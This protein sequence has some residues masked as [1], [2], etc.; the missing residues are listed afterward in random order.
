MIGIGTRGR[1]TRALLASVGALLL[2]LLVAGCGGGSA[3]AP[4]PGPEP[5]P[6][7][8]VGLVA[9]TV[10]Y[11]DKVGVQQDLA[12]S[13]GAA[14]LRENFSWARLEPRSGARDWSVL[15]RLVENAAT[16]HL[17][18]LP[19][20]LEPPAWAAAAD[21]GLPAASAALGAYVHDV[22]ARYGSNG[23]FWR[24]HP[25]LDRRLAPRWFELWNEPYLV[26]QRDNAVDAARYAAI[27]RVAVAAGRA[28]DPDA[29]FLIGV[30]S[31]TRAD[32]E[33]AS[34][35]ASALQQA[36]PGIW[37]AADGIAA[38]PYGIGAAGNGMFPLD[39]L[40]SVLHGIGV[41]LPIWIT[42]VGWS[43]CT[44]DPVCV[45]ES[46]QA[47]DMRT[48]LATLRDRYHSEVAAVFVYHLLDWP[49]T[50]PGG[51]EGAYGLLRVDG[52]HKPA[53]EVFRRFATG[54]T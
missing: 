18:L 16:R 44:A 34:R 14:W 19:L 5:A 35:W 9:N 21:G 45:P 49:V 33:L 47:D 41:R 3:P 25:E 13:A 22:V 50:P 2:T 52:S 29:R 32:P 48:V 4:A 54:G 17:Q 39:D 12:K 37:S 42:E 27:V 28:A 23:S 20:L 30:D 6:G 11:G 40:L 26:G 1:R 53:W 8:Y 36:W 51:R 38:H 43:T 10:G 31:S 15:D 46:A 7:L 24:D